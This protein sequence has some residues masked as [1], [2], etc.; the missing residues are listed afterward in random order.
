MMEPDTMQPEMRW[1]SEILFLYFPGAF[2]EHKIS[3]DQKFRG[4][5]HD[6]N[7]YSHLIMKT[8]RVGEHIIIWKPSRHQTSKY[9][10]QTSNLD[11]RSKYLISTQRIIF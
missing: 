5:C 6:G 11:F 2:V 9:P 1:P 8:F 3:F 10:H 7:V 4:G